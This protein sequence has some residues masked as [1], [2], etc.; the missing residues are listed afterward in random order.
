VLTGEEWGGSPANLVGR[1]SPRATRMA[2][3]SASEPSSLF[4]LASIDFG[5]CNVQWKEPN[6]WGGVEN[7]AHWQHKAGRIVS[8]HVAPPNP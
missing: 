3:M 1:A 5:D 2:L 4:T 6:E 7:K 8:C